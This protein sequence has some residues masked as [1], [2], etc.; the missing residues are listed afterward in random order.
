MLSS[1]SQP[2]IL[3]GL[4]AQA[5]Y[6]VF[7]VAEQAQ[8]RAA[9][10]ALQP[11][12]D[13]ESLVLGIGE[14]LVQSLNAHVEGLRQFPPLVGAGIEAPSSHGS[15][16]CWLRS[17]SA[18]PDRGALLHLARRIESALAPAFE[19]SYAIDAFKFGSG[20]DLTGYEDGTENPTGDDALRAALVDGRGVG[21][22]G[23]SFVA[24]QQW[25]HDLTRFEEMPS[26]QQDHAVGRRKS[27]NEEI[28]DAPPSAHVKRTAQESFTPEAFVLRRSMPWSDTATCGLMFVAFGR[29]FDAFEAQLRRMMGLDDGIVDALFDFSRPVTGHYFWCPPM[30]NGRID[31]SAVGL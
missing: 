11:L 27:D 24:I 1:L 16:W 15:L 2:G 28:E 30:K 6:L 17:T 21:R 10:R 19:L 29:S 13:G 8:I 31:L 5:R 23:A 9:L 12:L 4:P 14:S 25:R 3:A 22:N 7:T 18:Y 20:R 26:Q